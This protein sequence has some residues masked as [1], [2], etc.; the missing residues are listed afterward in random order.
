MGGVDYA[1]QNMRNIMERNF[2]DDV[3]RYLNHSQKGV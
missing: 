2:E 3:E 1:V